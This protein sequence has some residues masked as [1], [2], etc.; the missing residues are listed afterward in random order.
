MTI[1]PQDPENA[2]LTPGTAL[3]ISRRLLSAPHL[4][5]CYPQI[6]RY[7]LEEYPRFRSSAATMSSA[8]SPATLPPQHDPNDPGRG[9]VI[10]GVTWALTSLS[11]FVVGLRFYVRR[12]V[13]HGLSSDDWLMLLAVVSLDFR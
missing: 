3:L 13:L 12:R 4:F 1:E 10:V 9:P 5:C 2:K 8:S 11:L 7:H 6:L